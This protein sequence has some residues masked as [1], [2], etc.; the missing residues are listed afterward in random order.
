[1][2]NFTNL[3]S[4]LPIAAIVDYQ[5]LNVFSQNPGIFQPA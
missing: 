5:Y 3:G 1:M 4:Q 2:I